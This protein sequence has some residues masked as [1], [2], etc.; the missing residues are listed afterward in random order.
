MGCAGR[1]VL[2]KALRRHDRWSL[3]VAG[4]GPDAL[5]AAVDAARPAEEWR[6][7]RRRDFGGGGHDREIARSTRKTH[8]VMVEAAAGMCS[9]RP[10]PAACRLPPAARRPTSL[11]DVPVACADA[12]LAHVIP[13]FAFD[14]N[15]PSGARGCRWGRRQVGNP[16]RLAAASTWAGAG[17]QLSPGPRGAP[18]AMT[19]RG[20]VPL[21]S[22][23]PG[24]GA[25]QAV[26][27]PPAAADCGIHA[28]SAV[29]C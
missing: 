12:D 2:T 26:R 18:M 22:P 3:E 21:L 4:T 1:R 9:R 15:R 29:V 10:P 19:P 23:L 28:I 27:R 5:I 17:C 20:Y 8:K 6:A 16:V 24:S 25:R 14:R 7:R 13:F 11:A